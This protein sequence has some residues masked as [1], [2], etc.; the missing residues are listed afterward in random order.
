MSSNS[1][2][3]TNLDSLAYSY[4]DQASIQLARLSDIIRKELD[5]DPEDDHRLFKSNPFDDVKPNERRHLES[6]LLKALMTLGNHLYEK[7]S[8]LVVDT[9]NI[10]NFMYGTHGVIRLKPVNRIK[11]SLC[12]PKKCS[13]MLLVVAKITNLIQE[14]KYMSKRELYYKTAT[15][16]GSKL[17]QLNIILDDLCCLLGCSRV[18][19]RILCQPKGLVYGNLR[20][21]LK[22]NESFD[23][24]SSNEGTRIPTPQIPIVEIISDAKCII[25]IEKDSVLQKIIKQ[26]I[27]TNFVDTYKVI[28]FT[29]RGYPDINSRA[30]L[31]KLWT[32]LRIPIFVLTDADPHGAEIA[33]CYK[34][35]C[36]ATASEAS[37][38][39]VP[40][41]RWLGLLPSDVEKHPIPSSS[42]VNLTE[43][44]YNKIKSLFKRPYLRRKTD[45]LN[46][47]SLMRDMGKKAELECIDLLGDYLTRTFIPNKLRYASWL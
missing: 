37:Y 27:S 30:F 40:Q 36:F 41:I 7:N 32:H 47:L 34:F 22:N 23:C 4:L 39:A 44:D 26:E 38:L 16:C 17:Q 1:E 12:A 2:P 19:L 35:G 33:C 46:Q 15:L 29:A 20:F 6:K 9:R 28:L 18:H 21:K 13:L 14:D 5:F 42:L 25:I 45:W 10:E 11:F 24:L 31:N 3:D 8:V 43:H